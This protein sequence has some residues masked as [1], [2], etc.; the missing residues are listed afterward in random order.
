MNFAIILSGGVGRRMKSGP[1]PK[2]YIEVNQMPILAYTLIPF[3]KSN[4]VD[5]IVIV[6][7]E[8]WQSNILN[9]GKRYQITKMSSCM[10]LP[11][12]SRQESILN[13][14]RVCMEHSKSSGDVVII[15]DA[16]RPQ[17]STTL[18]NQCITSVQQGFDGCMPVLPVKD[19]IYQSNDGTEISQLLN[20]NLLYAGQAPEAFS[21]NKYYE[22]NNSFSSEELSFVCGSSEI[23]FKNGMKVR[24]IPGDESN[25]KLTTP[26][27]LERFKNTVE[28]NYESL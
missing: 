11:G 15:H 21:L 19:T 20:R 9:W 6:A 2:Q 8:E 14:L 4:M 28:V 23:A 24:L 5:E 13:G 26:E 12:A 1:I 10:A 25:Y 18:I 7:A 22:L 17:V 27:D 3:Q 16:V